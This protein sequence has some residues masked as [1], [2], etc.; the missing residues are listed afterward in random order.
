MTQ[1]GLM[2]SRNLTLMGETKQE[3]LGHRGVTFRATQGSLLPRTS[4]RKGQGSRPHPGLMGIL[5]K[6]RGHGPRSAG[7]RS[8]LAG[9]RPT[10][11]VW[12]RWICSVP[13]SV[14][15]PCRTHLPWRRLLGLRVPLQLSSAP[16]EATLPAA[17]RVPPHSNSAERHVS[18]SPVAS[19]TAR[20][21]AGPGPGL[22]SLPLP[23]TRARRPPRFAA[24]RRAASPRPQVPACSGAPGACR[25]GAW[26]AGPA[27][28]GGVRLR[29]LRT[30]RSPRLHS[31]KFNRKSS[32]HLSTVL[33][34]VLRLSFTG[35]SAQVGKTR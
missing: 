18:A 19:G 34:K 21:G 14:G 7:G 25:E 35:N 6:G 20:R 1:K 12:G 33:R 4:E 27:G 9:G 11:R 28:T 29:R 8:G 10:A 3:E 13:A 15:L 2:T 22:G 30:L 5:E 23:A 31:V 32:F 24:P 26:R 17:Q 16:R